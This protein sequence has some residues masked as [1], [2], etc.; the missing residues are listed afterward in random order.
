MTNAEHGII[1]LKPDGVNKNLE[2]K[3]YKHLEDNDL[4]IVSIK[5]TILRSEE[6]TKHI[7]TSFNPNE[8]S[9]YMSSGPIIAVMVKGVYAIDKLIKI[10]RKLRSDLGV[11]CD[12]M[13][14]YVHSADLGNEHLIQTKYLFPELDAG[15]HSLYADMNIPLS[16]KNLE[17]QIDFIKTN[18]SVSYI[19]LI[20][21]PVELFSFYGISKHLHINKLNII[22]GVRFPCVIKLK[23]NNFVPITIIGYFKELKLIL[24]NFKN[25]IDAKS[26]I[27]IIHMSRGVSVLD[28]LTY[29]EAFEEIILHLKNIHLDGVNVYD[30]RYSLQEVAKLEYISAD[31]HGLL[32]TGGSNGQTTDGSLSIDKKTFDLF[33]DKMKEYE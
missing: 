23:N 9:Q 28:Y 2:K 17:N 31:I 29:N 25:I 1:L 5:K 12:D 27:K 6:I 26:C 3:L 10:K 21:N 30:L 18:S 16:I 20:I 4:E 22:F 24:Q 14:N 33:M 13:Q 32:L 7:R 11:S 8:Y 19:G 15:I